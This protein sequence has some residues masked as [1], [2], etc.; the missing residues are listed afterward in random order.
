MTTKIIIKIECNERVKKARASLYGKRIILHKNA[1]GLETIFEKLY[2]NDSDM[3]SVVN[4]TPP[5]K[6]QYM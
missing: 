3:C 5:T 4:N 2:N 6:W 1:L